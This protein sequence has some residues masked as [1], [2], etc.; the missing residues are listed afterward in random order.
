MLKTIK[1][2]FSEEIVMVY[3]GIH[4]K[5]AS[6]YK[7]DKTISDLFS[8]KIPFY[9]LVHCTGEKATKKIKRTG[10]INNRIIKIGETIFI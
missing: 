3:G 9:H 4:L 1:E 10:I 6:D 2:S 8:L 7:I 5:G